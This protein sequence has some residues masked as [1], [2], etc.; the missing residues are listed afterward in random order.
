[1]LRSIYLFFVVTGVLCLVI[2][3]AYHYFK[4]IEP[5]KNNSFNIPVIKRILSL[6]YSFLPL[7]LVSNDPKE[8]RIRKALNY[9][10]YY[11]YAVVIIM[12]VGDSHFNKILID[13][14]PSR[15]IKL[16]DSSSYVKPLSDSE[17]SVIKDSFN[18][19]MKKGFP[20]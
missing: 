5:F 3:V 11:Y 9:G 18:L 13:E 7:R 16:V 8:N 2:K 17:K 12:A 6:L 15:P 19:E 14:A 1:M 20:K 4:K 10:L